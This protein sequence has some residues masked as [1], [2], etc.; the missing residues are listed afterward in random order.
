MARVMRRK[1]GGTW[2]KVRAMRPQIRAT[3]W[4]DCGVGSEPSQFLKKQDSKFHTFEAMH[5]GLRVVIE[6]I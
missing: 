4:T 5:Y 6:G 1:K 2:K 3:L